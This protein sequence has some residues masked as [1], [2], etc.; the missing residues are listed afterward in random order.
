MFFSLDKDAGNATGREADEVASKESGARFH[1][2]C[3]V[4]GS[5]KSFVI[6]GETT[7]KTT[8]RGPLKDSHVHVWFK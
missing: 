6:R 7:R 4:S 1:I 5:L 2:F 3:V 8:N